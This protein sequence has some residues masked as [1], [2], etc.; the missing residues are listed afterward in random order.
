MGQAAREEKRKS[1]HPKP[2][3]FYFESDS[4]ADPFPWVWRELSK[5]DA[6]RVVFDVVRVS[7]EERAPK[8]FPT[9]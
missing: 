4:F 6:C 9:T 3:S 7:D 5:E 2:D 8:N 1:C